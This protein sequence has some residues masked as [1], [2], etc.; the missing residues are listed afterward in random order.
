MKE[1]KYREKRLAKNSYSLSDYKVYEK[2]LGFGKGFLPFEYE[3]KEEKAEKAKIRHEYAKQVKDR[4]TVIIDEQR[5]YNTNDVN[6]LFLPKRAIEF[7]AS[8]RNR[9]CKIFN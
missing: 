9:V 3:T 1:A 8:K 5:K 2:N 7:D 6:P 4:N